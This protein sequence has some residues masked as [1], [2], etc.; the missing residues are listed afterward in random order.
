MICRVDFKSATGGNE[1][2][3]ALS[4]GG[5]FRDG[6][7]L[8]SLRYAAM[9]LNTSPIFEIALVLV[10]LDHIASFNLFLLRYVVTNQRRQY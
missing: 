3:A 4:P 9:R 5:S 2:P 1:S 8:L 6:A 7:A 10:R